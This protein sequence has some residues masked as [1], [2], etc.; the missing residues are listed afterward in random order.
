MS[1][2]SVMVIGPDWEKQLAPYHEY[3]CT[4]RKDEYVVEVDVTDEVMAEYDQS[5]KAIRMPDGSW[6]GR[7]DDR[8]YTG[9]PDDRW[10]NK[11]FVLPP[12]ATEIELAASDARSL[13]LGSATPTD[14]AIGY[15]GEDVIIKDDHFYDLTNPNKKWDWYQMGGRY[16]GR[17][18]LKPKAYGLVGRP[19]FMT[20]SCPAGYADQASKGDIDFEQMRNDAEVKAHALWKSTRALTGDASWESWDDTKIRYPNIDDA[21]REYADQPAIVA[22]KGSGHREYSW[23]VDDALALDIDIYIQRQRDRA[24]VQYAFVRDSLWTERGTMG[25][26]GMSSD[27][28]SMPQWCGMFNAM[29]DALSDDDIITI[30][31]CHI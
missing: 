21:R 5:V 27:E 26:F 4:G 10:S 13:G 18:K 22:L 11:K 31:D 3:E 23:E 16:T 12:G 8:F 9:A 20:E 19:G 14:A 29:I 17:L 30:V 7:Y 2:F 15:Y 6:H 28:V 24:C 1:H 25:W